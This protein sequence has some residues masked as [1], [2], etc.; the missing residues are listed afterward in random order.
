MSN[1]PLEL[2]IISTSYCAFP[3]VIELVFHEAEDQ[4]VVDDCR[5]HRPDHIK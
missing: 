2:Y 5:L 3:I 1:S 4:A